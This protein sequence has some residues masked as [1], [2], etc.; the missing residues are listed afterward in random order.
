MLRWEKVCSI[1]IDNKAQYNSSKNRD[2][3]TIWNIG[4]K[5]PMCIMGSKKK[6]KKKKKNDI[7]TKSKEDFYCSNLRTVGLLLALCS[8]QR[9]AKIL[10]ADF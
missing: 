6:K 9:K 3:F 10:N 8:N 2:I 5:G 4:K 7:S 1:K